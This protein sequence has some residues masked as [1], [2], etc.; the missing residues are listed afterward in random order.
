MDTGILILGMLAAAEYFSGANAG[1]GKLR[2]RVDEIYHRVEWDWACN[3]APT[4]S[5]GYSPEKGF[6]KY[7]WRGYNEGL[8]L[9]LLALGSAAHSLSADSYRAW[10]QTYQWKCVY[11][12]N[13]FTPGRYSF[14][15]SCTPGSIFAGCRTTS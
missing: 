1:N 12:T 4:L 9:Y 11:G 14:T 2:E 3:R 7:R 5:H 10:T 6:L 13:I 8:P 15:S